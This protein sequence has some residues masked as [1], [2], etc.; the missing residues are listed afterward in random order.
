MGSR[1]LHGKHLVISKGVHDVV[2]CL[3]VGSALASGLVATPTVE[4]PS[5]VMGQG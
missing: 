3:I 4:F 5:N 2:P 1:I